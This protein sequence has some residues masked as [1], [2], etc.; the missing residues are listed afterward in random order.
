M[1]KL[2]PKQTTLK[3]PVTLSGVGL[4][5]GEAVTLTFHP[6]PENH[7]YKFRRTDIQGQPEIEAD[8]D[9]V[10]DT[11]RGTTLEKK[12]VKIS[13]VEHVLAALVGAEIDNVLMDID[14]PEMPI[15]DGSSK[16]FI[17]ALLA[18]GS[19]E[20]EADR[21][22]FE[23]P[24]NIHYTD[25]AHGVEIIGMPVDEYRLTVMVD[26]NSQVLGSQHAAITNISEFKDQIASCR[27]FCFLHELEYLL[28]NN[29]I[30]G[31]DLN[32]AIVVVDRPVTQEEL[33]RLATVFKKPKVEVKK[34]GILNN[35][36]L[37][38]QNEPARHKLL[39][40]VGDLALVGMPIKGQIMAARPGHASNVAFARKIKQVMKKEMRRKQDGVPHYN[41]NDK[42]IYSTKDIIR[43]LPHKHPFLLVDKIIDKDE[44]SVTAVKNVTFDEPFFNGHFPGDPIMPGV[45]QL[46]AMAQAG[47]V[48]ILSTV[49]DP[50]NY[51]TLF[52]KIDNAKFKDKVV[53][54]DTLVMKMEL[55]EPVRRGICVMRAR[56]WVGEK[57]VSEAEMMAQIVKIA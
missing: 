11:S 20:Q 45:L 51:G 57:L 3:A 34:D 4:H 55:T 12:G 38:F 16:P 10:T 44:K 36:E 43:L 17:D 8:C 47:G 25:D 14:G 56:A 21:E 7:G 52:L 28:E 53:P 5:T 41:P 50:E 22:Y 33:D 6:A 37:R 23:I 31:G 1:S 15:L 24:Y 30:K 48:L 54:G 13:T 42:P 9:L 49:P 19:V 29:L 2:N 26:Y 32:N 35:L 40:M 39:D 46:E 18:T 27:T